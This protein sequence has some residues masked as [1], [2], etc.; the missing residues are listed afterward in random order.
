METSHSTL[1]GEY[2]RSKDLEIHSGLL[3]VYNEDEA[4]EL[5]SKVSL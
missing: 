1:V 4:P 3:E 5:I 2:R